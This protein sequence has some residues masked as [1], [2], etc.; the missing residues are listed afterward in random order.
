ME[1]VLHAFLE[2]IARHPTIF[3]PFGP[4]LRTLLAEIIGFSTPAYF[5]EQVVEAAQQLFMS[6]HK[7][8]PKDKSGSGWAEDCRSTILSTHRT[9]DHVFRAVIEQWESVDPSLTPTRQNYSQDMGDEGP[10]ALGLPGWRGMHAGADRLITLVQMLSEFVTMPS[11]S[12]V[13][14]PLGSILDLTSRFTSVTVPLEGADASQNSVQLNPQIGR[15]ER[16][17]LWTELPRIHIAC[18]DLLSNVAEVLEMSTTPVMQSIVEQA[19]WVFRSERFSK[20]LRSAIYDMIRSLITLNGPTMTKQSVVAL[21]NILRSC[22]LDLLSSVRDACSPTDAQSDRKSKLKAGQT[23]ANADSFLNPEIQKTHHAQISSRHT[24]PQRAASS[25]LQ[26]VLTSIAPEH[27]PPSV[28]AE[29]DRT[30]ILTA[31]KDAMLASVLNPVPAIKG[32]GAGSSIMPFLVRSCADQMEVEALVRPRMPVLM[33][34]PDLDG[35]AEIAEEEEEEA[36]DMAEDAH[37]T[38]PKTA[39]FLKQPVS[40]PTQPQKAE[41][42]AASA[43]ATSVHKRYY[44]EESNL[45]TSTLSS[46]PLEKGDVQT[47]KA[48]LEESIPVSGSQP[49][50]QRQPVAP[51]GMTTSVVFQPVTARKPAASTVQFGT[52]EA[53][54]R[55]AAIPE[56]STHTSTAPRE[57]M[58][59]SESTGAA[60]G[61]LDDSDEELPTLNIEPDTEEEDDV[62]MED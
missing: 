22:C 36:E 30:I 25:L 48:R 10:D 8:A 59:A 33:S 23:T 16:E 28:R 13:A 40:A 60:S 12:A 56:H 43:L 62:M 6:L 5:P 29:I 46:A 15:D 14:I 27:L 19:T 49:S 52:A 18:M 55:N 44:A 47:K 32:R 61:P 53:Q 41:L 34:A 45:E 1:T 57:Q 3:R 58:A 26:T 11:S 7:C 39:D 9:A 54:M 2:L 42:A 4:Q 24:G 20:D 38:A 51:T 37:N 50:E 35:Y 17:T 21:S 31:N